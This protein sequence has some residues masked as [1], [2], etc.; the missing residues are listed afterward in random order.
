MPTTF[1]DSNVL[2]DV[3]S[4]D[5]VWGAWSSEALSGAGA[6]GPLLINEV[7]YAEVSARYSR[8]EVLDRELS[9]EDFQR[10]H[11][12][13]QAAFLAGKAF[14]DYKRRGGSKRSP[15]PDFFIGAHA[16]VRDLPLLT[17]D[18]IRYRTYFPTVELI[19]PE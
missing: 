8:I 5:P 2:I 3:L 19:A 9:E 11:T 17:R 12:P 16:A 4:D 15:L 18:P 14:L 6:E 10:E 1:V 7:V 13:W